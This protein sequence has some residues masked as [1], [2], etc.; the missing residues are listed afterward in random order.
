M[1]VGDQLA[2]DVRFAQRE[3]EQAGFA[4]HGDDREVVL[5]EPGFRDFLP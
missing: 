1:T 5:F 3:F 2:S 4:K